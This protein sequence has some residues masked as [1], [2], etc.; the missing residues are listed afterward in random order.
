MI[1][2]VK[3]AMKELRESLESGGG[4]PREAPLDGMVREGFMGEVAC[5]LRTRQ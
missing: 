5:Q 1:S 4:I 3:K 2:T